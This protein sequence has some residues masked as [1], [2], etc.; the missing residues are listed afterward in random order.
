MLRCGSTNSSATLSRSKLRSKGSS[1]G[2][3]LAQTGLMPDQQL[4]SEDFMKVSDTAFDSLDSDEWGPDHGR[5][6][7]KHREHQPRALILS[8]L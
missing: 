4:A 3:V 5:A 8:D 6:L 1:G 2:P 7:A